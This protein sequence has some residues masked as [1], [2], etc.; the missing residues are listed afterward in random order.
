MTAAAAA[1]VNDGHFISRRDYEGGSVDSLFTVYAIYTSTELCVYRCLMLLVR[2]VRHE[3]A[4]P[5]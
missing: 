3:L 4:V 2:Q 5:N 1:E